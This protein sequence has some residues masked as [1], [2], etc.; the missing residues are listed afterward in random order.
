MTEIRGKAEGRRQKAEGGRRK[1]E[2]GRRKAKGGR[3]KAEGG[4]RKAEGERRKAE[5]RRQEARVAISYW[6]LAVG[7]PS[8]GS[9]ATRKRKKISREWCKDAS[10]CLRA[11]SQ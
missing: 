5:G 4:R 3:Q 7:F 6:P 2:G 10:G 9:R 11:N 8:D 1:A